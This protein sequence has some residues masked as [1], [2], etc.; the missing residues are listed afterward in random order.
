MNEVSSSNIF[1]IDSHCHLYDEKFDKDREQIISQSFQSLS[2][3]VIVIENPII[4][5]EN[6]LYNH[7]QIRYTA[8]YHPY[9]AE[10]AIKEESLK[11]LKDFAINNNISAIGEIGLDYYHCTVS[12]ETQKIAFE[13]Q[14]DLAL[15]LKLPVVIHSRNAESDTYTILKDFSKLDTSKIVLH[16]YGGSVEKLSKFLEL[17]CYISF[18]GNIT[19]PKAQELRECVKLTP[20]DRLLV[21]TD[22]PYLAPQQVRGKRCIPE[23]VKFTL[24]EVAKIKKL[25]IESITAQINVNTKKIFGF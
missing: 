14:L 11:L 22:A 5:L 25:D 23:Y 6:A 9:F 8:G 17:G 2:G 13:A 7:A 24:I 4:L 12:K 21:E 19:Y 10:L 15:S 1:P 20:T 3:I 18:A 16:C